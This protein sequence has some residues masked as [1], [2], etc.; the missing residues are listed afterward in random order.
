[1]E[2]KDKRENGLNNWRDRKSQ[3][4]NGTVKMEILDLKNTVT[5]IFKIHYKGSIADLW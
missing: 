2:L 4:R 1:M 5:E 3:L